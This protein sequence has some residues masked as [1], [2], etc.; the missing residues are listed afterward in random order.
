L[1]EIADFPD[2]FVH[3]LD[4]YQVIQLQPIHK[5]V[6]FLLEHMPPQMHLVIA[7]RTDPPLPLARLRAHDQLN[8]VRSDDLRFTP[9]ESVVFLNQSMG[10]NLSLD[11]V[12]SLEAHTEGWI[13]GLQL[14]ALALQGYTPKQ[15][16]RTADEF[17]QAFTGSHRYIVSYLVEEVLN[18]QPIG[19]MDFLLQTSILDRLSGPLCDYM[20]KESSLEDSDNGRSSLNSQSTLEQLVQANLFI[21]PLDE[22]GK[23]YRYHQLFAEVLRARLQK[24][25]PDKPRGLHLRASVWYEQ[26]GLTDP[27]LQHALA[28]QAIDRAA[29]LVEQAA[30]AM[31]QRSELARLLTWLD[32]LPDDEVQA[33]PRLALYY[34]WGLL[35]SGEFKQA[36]TRLE[37]VEALLASDEAKQTPEVQGHT[38]A[39]RARLLRESGD[40]ASTIALSRKGLAQLPKQDTML[41]ARITLDLTIAHYLQGE[42]EPATQLLRETIIAGQTAQQM[43]TTFSAIYMNVQV[44][45]AQGALRLA[46]QLCQ[47]ELELVARRGWQNFPAA[48]FL[49]VA[50][51]DLL[52]ERNELIAATEYLERG[53]N[54]GQSGGNS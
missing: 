46:L 32:T 52:R 25:Q 40:L 39:M 42:F 34:V 16:G 49:Y 45:R 13:A 33:R 21:V 51:G 8:E 28:A 30:P 18:Q 22:E 12:L 20:L 19:T 26:A 50:F 15:G 43:L 7:S 23:W 11:N 2:S 37:A 24:H 4:D 27:A 31:I 10:L 36:T 5:A 47:E 53:I 38:A 54:L 29:T 17:I 1:N 9:D 35:L 41:R 48:G 6:L 3:V 44:L 14:A